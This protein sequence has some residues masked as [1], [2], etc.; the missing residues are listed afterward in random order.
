ML[1]NRII[2]MKPSMT[3]NLTDKLEALKREGID[4]IRLNIG[5]PDFQTPANISKAAKVA[6]DNDFTKYT[7]VA[8]CIELREAICRKFELDNNIKYHTDEII[9]TTGAKQALNNALLTLCNKGDEVIVL[10]PCWV[11][12][13]EMVKLT[14]A[15]PVL[16]DLDG[17]EGFKL[18]IEIIEKV[19]C[20]KTKAILINT[21]NNPTGA[22]YNKKELLNLGKLAIEHD[23]YIIS[24]EIYEKFI[25]GDNKH[26]S[27]AS[28]SE[29]IK[30]RVITISGFSKTY[31]MTGWRLGYAGGTKAIIKAMANLQGHMTSGANSIAQ[32]AGVEALLGSQDSVEK[33]INEYKCRRKY[34]LDRLRNINEIRCMDSKGAFYLMPDISKIYGRKYRG[35]TLINSIDIADFLL[36]EAH[37]AI[38]PGIAFEAPNNI[39]IAYCNS[40][41]N[42]KEGMNRIEKSLTKLD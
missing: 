13:I 2:N 23:F 3:V 26:I 4:I 16:V 10:T 7:Q 18:D 20:D 6:V 1:S 38:V 19:I 5:E 21:P 32:K 34:L 36:E 22:V 27:I 30:K 40:L 39:R 15:K 35:K 25:Y 28:L 11:S 14:G 31:A 17:N 42:I 9:V 33:M 29:D 12:Y 24:D 8:G 41:E 37:V